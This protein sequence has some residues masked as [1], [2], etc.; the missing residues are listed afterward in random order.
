MKK[1]LLIFLFLGFL[2]TYFGEAKSE[3]VCSFST[4]MQYAKC[5]KKSNS[6]IIPQYPLVSGRNKL[7]PD[8]D[9]IWQG[10]KSFESIWVVGPTY[11]ILKFE[12]FDGNEIKVTKSI[13]MNQSWNYKKNPKSFLING[14]DII[15]WKYNLEDKY[16]NLGFKSESYT[17]D[18]NFINE[19]GTKKTLSG[20]TLM[21]SGR[22]GF[23]KFLLEESSGM[24]SN[25]ERVISE[26]IMKKLNKNQKRVTIIQSILKMPENKPEECIDM[27]ET[28]FPELAKEYRKLSKTINPLREKLDLPPLSDLKPICN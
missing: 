16:S 12:T 19:S 25:Q 22:F 26:M 18:I 13:N 3:E 14:E 27:N 4:P 28:K 6:K 10:K 5:K 2:S 15:S 11:T 23:L 9:F 17:F 20:R 8:D 7:I 21:R 1:K 24:K